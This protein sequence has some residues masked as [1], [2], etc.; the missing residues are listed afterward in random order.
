MDGA[1]GRA[2]IEPVKENGVQRTIV[3][4]IREYCSSKPLFPTLKSSYR[5]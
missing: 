2:G 5:Y 3:P 1:P 4:N